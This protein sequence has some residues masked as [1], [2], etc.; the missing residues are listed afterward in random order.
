LLESRKAQQLGY[1]ER[2]KISRIWQ[3]PKGN[4]GERDTRTPGGKEKKEERKRKL[5]SKHNDKRD[6]NRR[7]LGGLEGLRR[8]ICMGSMLLKS[9]KYASQR[10]GSGRCKV[11]EERL[12]V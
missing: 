1:K 11:L 5:E 2:Q 8:T 10:K 12:S 6:R 4:L 3:I 9:C 7:F